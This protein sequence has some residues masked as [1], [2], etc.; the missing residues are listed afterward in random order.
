MHRLPVG[1]CTMA[2]AG[3]VILSAQESRLPSTP[4]GQFGDSITGA[5]DG[6][7][8][9]AD[10]SRSFLV[11]YYN[12]NTRQSID[13][14]VGPN[15]RIDPGGPDMGQPTHFL[16]GRN[17]GV[18]TVR[19]PEAFTATDTLTWTLVAN[20]QTTRIPLRVRDD[21]YVS[22]LGGDA[23]GNTP[24]VIR[25]AEAGP[26]IVGPVAD[27]AHPLALRTTLNSPLPLTIWAED[28]ARHTSGTN[29]PLR[30]PPPPVAV[31]WSK[32]RG[33][34][35]VRFASSRPALETLRGGQ[36]AEPYAGRGATTATFTAPG[37]YLLHA[38]VTDFSGPGGNGEVC[39]WTTSVVRVLVGPN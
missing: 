36:V 13:I 29:A 38:L 20:G 39:C 14:P 16:P 2:L 37:E 23:I 7:F 15:N 32:Y 5:F 18:F 9:Q 6:W 1:L 33:P 25:F 11:G 12:R 30:N 35:V 3:T 19:V 4:K 17:V 31:A 24:P 22:P 8:R 27:A 26:R 21:Y 34:G 10:G 28:D